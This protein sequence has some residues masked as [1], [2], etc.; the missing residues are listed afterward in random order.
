MAKKCT[1]KCDASANLCF[2]NRKPTG[3]FFF[4]VFVALAVVVTKAPY[5]CDPEIL[6]PWW[7]DITLLSMLKVDCSTTKL[8]DVSCRKIAKQDNLPLLET[9]KF[10]DKICLKHGSY[11]L[12]K[13]LNL[14]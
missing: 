9:F 3:I 12:E 11:K 10:E 14:V 13:V 1:K 8:R 2:A 5:C 6:L 4:A 7:H